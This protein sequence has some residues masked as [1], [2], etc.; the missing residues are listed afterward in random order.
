MSDSVM[1]NGGRKS[2]YVARNR[3]A[4]LRATQETLAEHGSSATVEL[5]AEHA[6]MAVSTIYKH[7]PNK[8]VLFETAFLAGMTEWEEW[9]DPRIEPYATCMLQYSPYDN[10]TARAY[11]AIFAT[12]G[13][14]DPRVACHEPAKWVAKIRS[15]RT[16]DAP[17][18]LRTEM[19]AGHGGPSG[20]YERWREEARVSAFL[21]STLT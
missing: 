19:G 4:L 13:L 3:A 16:N 15:L 8:E 21:L 18:L 7:F 6:Q 10:V 17:L 1:P 11:P 14:N 20:R 12:G 2:A 5:V 9:G